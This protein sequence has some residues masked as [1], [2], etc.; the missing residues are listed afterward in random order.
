[1]SADDAFLDRL[2]AGLRPVPTHAV[3]RRL[4]FA[5]IAGGAVAFAGVTIGMGLR[6]DM[7]HALGTMMFWTKLGYTGALMA[8]GAWAMDRLARPVG[9]ARQRLAWGLLPLLF[10]AAIAVWQ[11]MA[12]PPF[13]RRLLVMGETAAF[14]PWLILLTAVPLFGALVWALRGLAPTRLARAGAVAGLTA[15]AAGAALYALH[16]PETGAPFVAIWY[17]LGIAGTGLVGRLTG[18]W[19]LRW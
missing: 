4:G 15:G 5:L 9:A 18:P 3:A 2:S 10:I 8:V 17:T 16:C 19:L 11:I 12:A 7:R 14:C 6:S 13:L 1:M